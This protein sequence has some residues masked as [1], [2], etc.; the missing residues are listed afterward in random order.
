MLILIAF[1]ILV[2]G[3]SPL[4][5]DE[6]AYTFIAREYSL[7]E[8]CTLIITLLLLL[9]QNILVKNS[10]ESDVDIYKSEI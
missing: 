10:D 1:R 6:C 8:R 9:L 5:A 3:A 2:G 4:D 7:G